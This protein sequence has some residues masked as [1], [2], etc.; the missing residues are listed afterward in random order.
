MSDSENIT[1]ELFSQEK[2]RVMSVE[3][4]GKISFLTL[5]TGHGANHTITVTLISQLC[6]PTHCIMGFHLV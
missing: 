5:K 1:T 3:I 6:A 2:R 4:K